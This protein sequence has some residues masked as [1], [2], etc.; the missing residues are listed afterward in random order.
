[1]NVSGSEPVVEGVESGKRN[2]DEVDQVV[3]SKGH[4]KRKGTHEHHHPKHVDAQQIEQLCQHRG[5]QENAA[6]ERERV[7]VNPVAR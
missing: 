6:H 1:M 7:G 4:G 3:A 2:A 5:N